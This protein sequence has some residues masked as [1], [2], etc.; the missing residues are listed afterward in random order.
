[1]T[2]FTRKSASATAITT[3]AAVLIAAVSVSPAVSEEFKFDFKGSL[4]PG[5]HTR[6]VPPLANPLL[7]ETPY[8]TTEARP[9]I[10]Y[11]DIPDSF[12]T[13]GGTIVIGAVEVRI[14]LT[15]RLGFIASKDGYA[16]LDF[17]AVLPDA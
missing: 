16:D 11:N 17:D 7:N 14:A 15:E 1:M 2:T 5:R 8:I 13:G 3:L 10:L 9:L 6:Y 4:G 12:L